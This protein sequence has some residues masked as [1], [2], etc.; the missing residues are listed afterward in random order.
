MTNDEAIAELNHYIHSDSL[1]EAPSNEACQLAVA[2]LE[3][4]RWI[5]NPQEYPDTDS[6]VVGY[7]G[8]GA[9]DQLRWFDFVTTLSDGSLVAEREQD[10]TNEHLI[11]VFQLPEPPK[12]G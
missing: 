2:A 8:G 3:R 1:T 12:E 11:A 5:S 10:V 6:R 7:F 9:F 4:D